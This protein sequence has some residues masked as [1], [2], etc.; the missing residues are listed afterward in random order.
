MKCLTELD[1]DVDKISYNKFCTGL[2]GNPELFK[3]I[4]GKDGHFKPLSKIIFKKTINC[5]TIQTQD[6]NK[7]LIPAV[8]REY[9]G[10]DCMN[11]YKNSKIA[12]NEYSKKEFDNDVKFISLGKLRSK[13]EGYRLPLSYLYGEELDAMVATFYG[14]DIHLFGK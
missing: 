14:D 11:L 10:I 3:E 1:A 12:Y 8:I 7:N 4:L 5:I 2:L 6:L 13:L 9:T